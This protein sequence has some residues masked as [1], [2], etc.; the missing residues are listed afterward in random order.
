LICFPWLVWYK[1]RN[2]KW[3]SQ[4]SITRMLEPSPETRRLK[5][6]WHIIWFWAYLTKS[7][8]YCWVIV[9]FFFI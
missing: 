3:W 8:G 2:Y 4:S 7:I 1:R 9:I 5:W 6:Q